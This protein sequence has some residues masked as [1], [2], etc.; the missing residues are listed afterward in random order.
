MKS[1]TSTGKFFKKTR[2]ITRI[3]ATNKIQMTI[4]KKSF[5][6]VNGLILQNAKNK[7]ELSLKLVKTNKISKLIQNNLKNRLLMQKK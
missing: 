7:R 2:L 4:I 6:N 5:P 3:R 1:G